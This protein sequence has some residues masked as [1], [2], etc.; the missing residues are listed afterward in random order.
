MKPY[1]QHFLTVCG[2]AE[3]DKSLLL[4]AY[5]RIVADEATRTTWE[6]L[7]AAYRAD[8]HCDYAA[9]REEARRICEGLGIHA[10]TAELLLF[11]CFSRDTLARYREQGLS[12][13]LFYHTMLD[14]RYKVEEC[15]AMHGIC[16]SFVAHWFTG[17][18]DLTRFAFGRL[19]F[20]VVSFGKQYRKGDVL[21]TETSPVIN[22]HIPRT[23]TP[24]SPASCDEAFCLAADFFRPHIGENPLVFVCHSWLLYPAQRDFLPKHSNLLSFMDRFE[25]LE[26]KDFEDGHPQLWRLFDR[27]YDGNP[28]HLP[29]DTSLRRA[30]VDRIKQGGKTG[31]GYGLFFYEGE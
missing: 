25:L 15:K 16:G 27:A 1:L 22:I 31:E 5:D 3:E 12:E 6:R 23:G 10:Y 19:Q 26:W 7:M 30:Y 2:Y 21:L 28:D 11:L 13:E 4:E 14:L 24:L 29:Y 17:F 8:V 9:L 18:F 20:E